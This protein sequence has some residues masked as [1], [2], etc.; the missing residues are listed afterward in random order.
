M[1]RK[2][3]QRTEANV[4]KP[5]SGEIR[6]RFQTLCSYTAVPSLIEQPPESLPEQIFRWLMFCYGRFIWAVIPLFFCSVPTVPPPWAP[7][8]RRSP[9][10]CCTDGQC[11]PGTGGP[12]S[13]R[14]TGAPS[15]SASPGSPA[16]DRAAGSCC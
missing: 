4:M 2:T 1:L 7:S 9:C 14:R 15:A 6:C 16:W 3:S 5:T 10:T 8:R 13:G 11:S 12:W